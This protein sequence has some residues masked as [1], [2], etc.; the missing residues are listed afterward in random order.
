MFKKITAFVFTLLFSHAV[1]IQSVQAAPPKVV[2][3]ILPVHALV[4]AVMGEIG[5]PQ[6]LL[7]ASSSPHAIAMKP[8][9]AR[10]LENADLVFWI[11]P[12]LETA[13]AEPLNVLANDAQV[14]SLMDAPGLDLLHAD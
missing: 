11:G 9:Q 4:L 1:L 10:A 12:D 14:V 2:T 8:S 6:L 3:S 5:A 13:L 7:D